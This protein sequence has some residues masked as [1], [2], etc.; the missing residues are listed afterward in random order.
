MSDI[1]VSWNPAIAQGDWS[2]E[3]GDLAVANGLD[4]LSTSVLASIFSDGAA[5]PDYIPTDGTNDRRGWWGSTFQALPLGSQ[6]WQL[7]RSKITN[8]TGPLL[9]AQSAITNAL[10]Y[11]QDQ[12]IATNINVSAAWASNQAM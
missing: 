4:E 3:N 6:L 7:Y 5:S 2:F 10:Q 11:L 12:G 1:L 8:N 9:Q